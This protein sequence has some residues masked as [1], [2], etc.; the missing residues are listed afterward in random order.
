MVSAAVI[1]GTK[2]GWFRLA[3]TVAGAALAAALLWDLEF[4]PAFW[5]D[6]GWTMM[7]ARNWVLDGFYGQMNAGVLQPPGLAAA[8]PVTASVALTFRLLGAGIWQ[9]RLPGV[10]FTL[11]ALIFLWQLARRLYGERAAWISLGLV[12]LLPPNDKLHPLILGRQALG[13]MPAIFFLLAGFFLFFIAL[14]RRGS[15]GLLALT[16]A[17]LFWGIAIQTKA[18]VLPAWVA[19]GLMASFACLLRK[20]VRSLLYVGLAAAGGMLAWQGALCL[21]TWL[22]G[23]STVAAEPLQDY[24]SMSAVVPVLHVRQLAWLSALAFGTAAAA[25]LGLAAWRLW[26]ERGDRQ[27]QPAV[28]LVRAALLGFVGSWFAWYLFLAMYWPRYLFPVL[29]FSSLFEADLFARWTSG[30]SLSHTVD[31][32]LAWLKRRPEG[33]WRALAALFLITQKV[34]MFVLIGWLFL[35]VLRSE[36]LQHTAVYLNRQAPEGA[37]VESYET[38]LLFLLNRAY[39][40]PPDHVHVALNKRTLIDPAVVVDY[41]PL[42]YESDYLVV[43]PSARDWHLYDGVIQSGAFCLLESFAPYDIYAR[44]QPEQPCDPRVVVR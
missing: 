31:S 20:D 30:F 37:L 18:Q 28:Y 24:L 27:V 26:V 13:E 23:A 7:L 10:V 9:G 12:L 8:F 38:Q 36:A 22:V 33:G 35:P 14:E 15:V 29:F 5:W 44:S 19:A 1:T 25:A 34:T 4:F 21:Q 32:A 40:Y 6:E 41:D 2:P 3:V 42:L 43:G 16:G 39:H 11:L 17:S